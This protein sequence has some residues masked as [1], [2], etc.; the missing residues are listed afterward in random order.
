MFERR[1]LSGVMDRMYGVACFRRKKLLSKALMIGISQSW[2]R[3]WNEEGSRHWSLYYLRLFSL[4][5]I[6]LHFLYTSLS[7]A[8]QPQGQVGNRLPIRR[9]QRT[10][11]RPA[12][13]A[14]TNRRV[15]TF[16][17]AKSSTSLGTECQLLLWPRSLHVHLQQQTKWKC[18]AKP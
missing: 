16:A 15:G 3:K 14:S 7:L 9:R 1:G 18:R 12:S 5:W 8:I 17:K 4:V 2:R 6:I 11:W 13:R 10:K